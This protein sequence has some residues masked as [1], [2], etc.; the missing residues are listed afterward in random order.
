MLIPS[1]RVPTTGRSLRKS[2]LEELEGWSRDVVER[3]SQLS[4]VGAEA[5]ATRI[6]DHPATYGELIDDL[7]TVEELQGFED[8]VKGR[9]E[10]LGGVFG[11][12]YNGLRTDWD[13]NN[14]SFRI[15]CYPRMNID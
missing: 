7:R 5:L 8:E 10:E 15:N 11:Q 12:L 1:R 4:K 9:S 6:S 3:L 14:I 2:T 13:K